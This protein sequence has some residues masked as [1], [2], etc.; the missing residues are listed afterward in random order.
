MGRRARRKFAREH[1][2]ETVRLVHSSGKSIGQFA[3]D[4]AMSGGGAGAPT[5]AP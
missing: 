3:R 5:S 4:G 1:K 2:T